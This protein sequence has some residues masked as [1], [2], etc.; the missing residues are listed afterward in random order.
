MVRRLLLHT[1][2]EAAIPLR[3]AAAP[4]VGLAAGIA[5]ALSAMS[6]PGP[7]WLRYGLAVI[8]GLAVYWA[9]LRLTLKL[10]GESLALTHFVMEGPDAG[11]QGAA[12][13]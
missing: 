9:A 7:D 6:L 5:A 4:L 10:M 8:A 12:G 3:Q 13:L 1:G 2:F 11:P